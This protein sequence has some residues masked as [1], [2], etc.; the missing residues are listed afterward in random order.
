MAGYTTLDGLTNTLYTSASAK[1]AA[2]I[3]GGDKAVRGGKFPVLDIAVKAGETLK[4]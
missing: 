4:I 2:L 1:V 3:G